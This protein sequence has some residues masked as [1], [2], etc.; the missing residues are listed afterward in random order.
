MNL[1]EPPPTFRPPTPSERPWWWRLEDAGGAE[2]ALPG[3]LAEEYGERR[4]PSQADAESWIGET[5]S[6]LKAAG[7]EAVTLL[8]MDRV[9]YGPMSLSA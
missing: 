3:D 2:V 8:E 6:E 4:F 9:V 1:P 5:W 7:V